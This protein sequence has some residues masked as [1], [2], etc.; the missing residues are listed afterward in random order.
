MS[1]EATTT[2]NSLE[3]EAQETDRLPL[4]EVTPH[5]DNPPP[6]QVNLSKEECKQRDGA[7][8]FGHIG[9]DNIKALA[10][11]H[12]LSERYIRAILRTQG[13]GRMKAIAERNERILD[14]FKAGKTR[15][16]IAEIVDMSYSLIVDILGDAGY[17]WQKGKINCQICGN[18]FTP[19]RPRGFLCSDKCKIEQKRIYDLERYRSNLCLRKKCLFCNNDFRVR[20]TKRKKQNFC[21]I[22]CSSLYANKHNRVRNEEVFYLRH[23]Q[24]LTY[25]RI[26]EIFGIVHT[27]ARK[28]YLKQLVKRN[29]RLAE[30]GQ[31]QKNSRR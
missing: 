26:A 2:A 17:G 25:T 12:M 28:I 20:K 16:E 23:V 19:K 13:A 9:G 14:L 3:V 24:G 27:T 10:K 11:K 15:I 22:S 18:L 8:L 21:S 6:E 5:P 1:E 31:V 7:I 29:L 30:L 4:S